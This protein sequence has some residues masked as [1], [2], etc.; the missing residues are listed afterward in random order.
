MCCGD[1]LCELFAVS[2][3]NTDVFDSVMWDE[4]ADESAGNDS[5]QVEVKLLCHLGVLI[6]K[7]D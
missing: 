1:V 2:R 5:L 6:N 4:G 3:D 7:C